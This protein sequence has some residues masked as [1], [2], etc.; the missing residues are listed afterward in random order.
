MFFNCDICRVFLIIIELKLIIKFE[1]LDI[2]LKK[3][4]CIYLNYIF[5]AICIE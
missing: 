1:Y 5:K 4:N 3:K 2:V